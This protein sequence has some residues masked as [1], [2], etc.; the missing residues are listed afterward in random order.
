MLFFFPSH[1]QS[2]LEV[3]VDNTVVFAGFLRIW[4]LDSAYPHSPLFSADVAVL[5]PKQFTVKFSVP[6]GDAWSQPRQVKAVVQDA[7]T[8]HHCRLYHTGIPRPE[9]MKNVD[10]ASRDSTSAS[11]ALFFENY[12]QLPCCAHC[13]LDVSELF[14]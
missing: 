12:C 1:S 3:G 7:N 2:L 6:S 10:S 14:C 11:L 13:V 5:C 9:T 4:I 8:V